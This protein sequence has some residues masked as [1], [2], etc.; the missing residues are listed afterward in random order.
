MIMKQ[1]AFERIKIRNT[2]IIDPNVGVNM[3]I[4]TETEDKT[5]RQILIATDG[6]QASETA[7]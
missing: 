7:V 3:E 5:H 6:S 1:S 4:N 2:G